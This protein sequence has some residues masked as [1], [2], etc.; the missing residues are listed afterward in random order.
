MVAIV[1]MIAYY[2][3][4]NVMIAIINVM[5]AIIKS[6]PPKYPYFWENIIKKIIKYIIIFMIAIIK[7][8]DILNE[9]FNDI[10]VIFK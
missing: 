10:F 4:I 6:W 7:N 9:M 2:F 1:L 8:N 3:L 5:I